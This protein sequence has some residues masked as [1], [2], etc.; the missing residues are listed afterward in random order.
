MRWRRTTM[1]L[2]LAWGSHPEVVVLGHQAHA[3]VE[4]A[5][6]PP[7]R[8]P[9]AT[10][11]SRARARASAADGAGAARAQAAHPPR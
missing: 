6:L 2:L 4:K 9:V 8:C 11:P 7:L 1:T 5:G 10:V 3:E